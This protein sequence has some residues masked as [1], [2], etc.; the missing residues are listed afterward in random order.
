M[1]DLASLKPKVD[2][3]EAGDNY[4]IGKIGI[5]PKL[6]ILINTYPWTTLGV[7]F[8]LLVIFSYAAFKALKVVRAKRLGQN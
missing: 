6:T 2:T 1:V 3:M 4:Y 5:V 7:A 8:A